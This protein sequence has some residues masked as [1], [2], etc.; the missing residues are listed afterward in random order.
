MATTADYAADYTES[1]P[2]L[3][4]EVEWA[5]QWVA[6][7]L[8]RCADGRYY[9]AQYDERKS[10]WSGPTGPAL[11]RQ[12]LRGW[13]CRTEATIPSMGGVSYRSPREAVTRRFGA[14]VA[15]VLYPRAKA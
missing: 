9:V 3:E 6:Q 4:Q 2:T 1:P 5:Q 10:Q 12:G 15:D 13:F 7:R 14:T 8:H 11:R